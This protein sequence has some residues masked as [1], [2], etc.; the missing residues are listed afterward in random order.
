MTC[1]I[2]DNKKLQELSNDIGLA[3]ICHSSRADCH[4]GLE[5]SNGQYTLGAIGS[6]IGY[7]QGLFNRH[8]DPSEHTK[9]LAD[10][11]Q[12][13]GAPL[14]FS[15]ELLWAYKGCEL[16]SEYRRKACEPLLGTGRVPIIITNFD[17][18]TEIKEIADMFESD[19]PVYS[20]ETML[21]RLTLSSEE[22]AFECAKLLNGLVIEA[23]RAGQMP[24]MFPLFQA[25]LCPEH[26][27]TLKKLAWKFKKYVNIAANPFTDQGV[28]EVER[29]G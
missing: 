1:R 12:Q 22:S 21:V 6:A 4:R 25:D 9:Y 14:P 17:P 15:H 8:G 11:L 2:A 23:T 16:P 26:L 24:K 3:P 19:V 27:E 28:F 7:C 18:A 10:K 29:A 20:G 5:R 13:I